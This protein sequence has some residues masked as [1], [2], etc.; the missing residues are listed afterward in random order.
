MPQNTPK[1]EKWL[2]R[3]LAE[4]EKRVKSLETSP[5]S[6]NASVSHGK[7]TVQDGTVELVRAG[8]LGTDLAG[9]VRGTMMRR[10]TGELA[11]ATWTGAGTDGGGFWAWYDQAGNTVMSDD[12]VSGQGLAT[13]WIG[14]PVFAPTATALWPTATSGS[15]VAQ[16]AAQWYKQQPRVI[17]QVWT[18]SASGTSG[19]I[20]VSCGGASVT[21]SVG[22]GDNSNRT[23]ALSPAGTFGANLQIDIEMRRTG[24]SGFIGCYPLSVFGAGS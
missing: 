21:A 15:Y 19:D 17:V 5:R 22:S 10:P 1:D 11:Y 18:Q 3:R 13:P 4:L 9:D 24:G 2:L 23:F 6:G 7:F 8:F 16:W 20:R 14:S 12:A